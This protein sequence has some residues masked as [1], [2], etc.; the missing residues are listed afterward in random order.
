MTTAKF[1]FKVLFWFENDSRIITEIKRTDI[2]SE[3]KSLVYKWII[4][5]KQNENENENEKQNESEN[6]NEGQISVLTFQSMESL[7][8]KQVREFVEGRLE[9]NAEENE[10]QN[11]DTTSF[12]KK[13]VNEAVFNGEKLAPVHPQQVNERWMEVIAGFFSL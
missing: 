1:P 7:E 9:W 13:N 4:I 10:K 5:Q 11:E 8:D 2:Q 3:D 12:S 6:E